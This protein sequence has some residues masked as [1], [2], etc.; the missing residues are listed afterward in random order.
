MIGGL[1]WINEPPI[2]RFFIGTL[3]PKG[4]W[5]PNSLQSLKLTLEIRFNGDLKITCLDNSIQI[6][7]Y[8]SDWCDVLSIGSYL[9][10]YRLLIIERL[11][12]SWTNNDEIRGK[13]GDLD[14]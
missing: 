13:V 10:G 1:E 14:L 11:F 4:D 5:P 12:G 8:V 7:L 2:F 3:K 9:T 6:G